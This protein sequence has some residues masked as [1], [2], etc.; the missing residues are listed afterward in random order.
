MRTSVILAL[1]ALMV[2][3]GCKRRPDRLVTADG[4]AYSGK[5]Q[6]IEGSRVV[7]DNTEAEMAFQ[8][9]RVF[10]NKDGISR[11]G[12]IR[13]SDGKFSVET[14]DGQYS[15]PSK[16]VDMVIWS[17]PSDERTISVDVPASAGWME[18]GIEVSNSDR[19][20]IRAT[21]RV[22]M[23]TGTSGPSGIDYYST[24]LALVPQATNG[25]L[26]MMVGESTPIAAGSTWTGDSPGSG[27]LMLAVNRPNRESI[28]GV[29]GSY[30]VN[31]TVTPGPVGNSVLYPS[32][33]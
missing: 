5:L 13:F 28:E 4:Q 14:G 8:E 11:R 12:Y 7:F 22:S 9:A 24:A 25:E 15:Y 21:G 2:V 18:S 27:R 29:G 1:L 32:P 3:T 10:V 6:S 30:S 19:L 26:V 20:V 16:D 33:D 23:E 31:V 17:D